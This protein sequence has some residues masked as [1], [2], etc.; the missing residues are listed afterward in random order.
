MDANANTA[1]RHESPEL[2]AAA[3]RM[4]RA[5]IRRAQEGDTE[6]LEQ[7]V[8]LEALVSASVQ[9]AGH[10]MW[11]GGGGAY[12]WSELAAVLGVTRAAVAKRFRTRPSAAHMMWLA[13][14]LSARALRMADK[15]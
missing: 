2:G 15:S 10:L 6:A 9:Q 8:A 11:Q 13:G 3:S 5:L 14:D 7:L 1:R 12:S 4:T